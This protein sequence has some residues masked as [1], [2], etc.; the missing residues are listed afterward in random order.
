[1]TG[2]KVPRGWAEEYYLIAEPELFAPCAAELTAV[3]LAYLPRQR[4]V[5]Q[6]DLSDLADDLAGGLV[7]E[8][9][10]GDDGPYFRLG[11]ACYDVFVQPRVESET[12]TV[13][14]FVTS[15]KPAGMPS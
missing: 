9:R 11:G 6:H 4:W 10:V 13:Q 7:V 12:G 3:E 15:V 14:A 2:L 1:M 5:Q 8:R